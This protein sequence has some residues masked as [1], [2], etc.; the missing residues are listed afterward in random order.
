[1]MQSKSHVGR[2]A[3]GGSL[4]AR[5]YYLCCADDAMS[6][7][8]IWH[9]ARALTRGWHIFIELFT[10]A[11]MQIFLCPLAMMGTSRT[12]PVALH[13]DTK[14]LFV[15]SRFSCLIHFMQLPPMDVTAVEL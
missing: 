6:A 11:T 2:A 15:S 12:V 9:S 1:M 10:L 7:H 14:L 5:V 3:C 4:R 8:I 13:L